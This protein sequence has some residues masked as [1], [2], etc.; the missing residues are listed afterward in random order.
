M[1]VACWIERLRILFFPKVEIVVGKNY[2]C[3]LQVSNRVWCCLVLLQ[4]SSGVINVESIILN[5][6]R[7][8][9][10]AFGVLQPGCGTTRAGSFCG[11]KSQSGHLGHVSPFQDVPTR[12][13]HL[14]L[15]GSVLLCRPTVVNGYYQI[16][17]I[18]SDFFGRFCCF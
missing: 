10:G 8:A 7:R 9:P 15:C 17:G 11:T 16:C 14:L 2:S 5:L 18:E 4:F 12:G 13:F 3:G 6:C 1:G